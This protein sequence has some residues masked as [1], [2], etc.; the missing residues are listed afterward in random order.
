MDKNWRVFK[1][2]QSVIELFFAFCMVLA[3]TVKIVKKTLLPPNIVGYLFWFSLGI[4]LGFQLCK[5]IY[6][7]ELKKS[8]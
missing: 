3:A 6:N 2:Y 8:R 5:Y 1:I 4:Y 7:K